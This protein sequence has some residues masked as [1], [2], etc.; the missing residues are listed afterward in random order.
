VSGRAGARPLR[1][2][3]TRTN[4]RQLPRSGRPP[5]RPGAVTSRASGARERVVARRRGQVAERSRVRPS[6]SSAASKRG[7][8]NQ[9]AATSSKRPTSRS[10]GRGHVTREGS[11]RAGRRTS[12]RPGRRAIACPAE[13]ELGRFEEG[14]REPTRASFLEAADLPV[15]RARSR[16][17]RG[18]RASGPS[19]VGEARSQSDRV[20][21][22]AGARPLRRGGTRT[23]TRQLPR[24]GRPPGRPGAVTSRAR[25]ARERA[26]AR[27]RGQVAER[28]RVR[29]SRSSAASKRGS[30]NQHAATSSK[31]PTSRSAGRGHVTRERSV[32]A[33]RRTSARPGRRAIA[34]P[35]EQ[36][37]GRFE[38]GERQPT[39]G[40]FLE[41]ADLPVGR[42]A[43]SGAHAR[44]ER[45]SGSSHVGEVRSQSDRVSGRAGARPRRRGGT[46]TNTRQLPRSGRP[47]GRPSAVTSRASG[48]R[49]RVVARRRGQVAERSRVRPSRSSAASK[50]GNANQH[51]ANFLEA[52]DLP[53]GRARSRHARA[54]RASGSS[55]V[56]EVRSRRTCRAGARATGASEAPGRA[57]DG[58]T[59][60]REPS[61]QDVR[62]CRGPRF[63]SSCGGSR[64]SAR[65]PWRTGEGAGTRA[66]R[67]TRSAN[68]WRTCRVRSVLCRAARRRS[69]TR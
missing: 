65:G 35:A 63:G 10:A 50:R 16:H 28:S 43:V 14:E 23:N 62:R 64:R 60:P 17:G 7:S 52:A 9:H 40:N 2:G 47:P 26:V 38:E 21:G 46:R 24:S 68:P 30:A 44:A 11:A 37:L 15:G 18:E 56:G 12:A 53:V 41:A 8:A 13:Q 34:C 20:S 45:A 54:E 1:R 32:R 42:G 4:T 29:P 55:H 5:G 36:E 33:G 3:G 22:R 39:R 57:A 25:G 19:H 48:A 61:L 67:A 69:P 6:R 59:S 31:R 27:R 49:E 66:A 51:A 58:S